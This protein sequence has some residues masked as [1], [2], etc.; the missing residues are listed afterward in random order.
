MSGWLLNK[1]EASFKNEASLRTYQLKKIY[2][3]NAFNIV[4]PMSAGE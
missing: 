3:P 1:S 2:K 4:S